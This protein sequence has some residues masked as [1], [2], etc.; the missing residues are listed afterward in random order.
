MT[1]E[2][3]IQK[4]EVDTF[5][6]KENKPLPQVLQKWSYKFNSIDADDRL[7]LVDGS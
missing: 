2:S 4:N 1:V 5:A 3:L 7:V 6:K